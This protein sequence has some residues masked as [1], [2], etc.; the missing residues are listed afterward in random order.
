MEAI[1]KA[2][3]IAIQ[4]LGAE[5]NDEEYLKEDDLK[6]V[7]EAASLMQAA[8]EEEKAVLRQVSQELGYSDWTKHIGID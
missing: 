7:E 6:I 2:L 4:Y 1:S 3:V 5:R 8:T